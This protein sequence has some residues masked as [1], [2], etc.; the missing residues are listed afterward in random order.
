MGP[1]LSFPAC[2][3][4]A[5][6][7]PGAPRM[8]LGWRVS[9]HS[10]RRRGC[11]TGLKPDHGHPCAHRVRQTRARAP[12]SLLPPLPLANGTGADRTRHQPGAP[13]PSIPFPR[14]PKASIPEHAPVQNPV[15]QKRS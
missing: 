7:A 14:P 9:A 11:P 2:A 3:S 1:C 5:H 12:L 15:T 13:T 10:K 4:A 8:E 6:P